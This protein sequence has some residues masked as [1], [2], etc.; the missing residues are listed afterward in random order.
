MVPTWA[1]SVLPL[2]GLACSF[3]FVDD[4][5]D[6][7]VDAAL[8]V[9]GVVPGGHQLGALGVDGLRQHG[10]GRRAV[11]GDVGGLGGHLLHHLRAQVRQLVLELDLLGDGDAVLG[12][13]RASP[14]TSR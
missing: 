1:I 6:G 7:G 11:A 2:V 14:T 9:H 5:R 3:R 8:D 13:R 10:R 12:D 4:L